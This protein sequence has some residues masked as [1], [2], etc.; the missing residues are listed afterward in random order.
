[1]RSILVDTGPLVALCDDADALHARAL[2]ELDRL[3][4][5][6][7]V[8]LPVLTE[9]HFL[10]PQGHLRQRLSGLL[11]AGAFRVGP[12][13][14]AE[15]LLKKSLA[16]LERYQEHE[17]DFTDAFLVAWAERERQALIWTFD[18]E[19]SRIWRTSAG[20]KLRLA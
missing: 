19:F 13:E 2:A 3:K 14:G 12:D 17:P 18:R 4:G 1:M 10:L 5:P 16:W 7:F 20:K 6:F 11:I 15:A 9:A 8:C